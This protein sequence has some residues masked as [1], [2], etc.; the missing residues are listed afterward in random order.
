MIK[1]IYRRLTAVAT[2]KPERMLTDA[3]LKFTA[4]LN[5]KK[6]IIPMIIGAIPVIGVACSFLK[7]GQQEIS[8]FGKDGL[9]VPI[10]LSFL[11]LFF[12]YCCYKVFLDRKDKLVI[13]AGGIWLHKSGF[14][15]WH[16]I[17]YIYLRIIKGKQTVYTLF[18][19]LNADDKEIKFDIT[20]LDKTAP[21]ILDALQHYS[22]KNGILFLD[23]EVFA[24]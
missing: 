1:S 3:Q 14:I 18:I 11:L 21:E 15:E 12:F 20:D 5:R 2:K 4:K 17:W 22:Q 8:E 10:L 16:L 23:T 6:L 24:P 13:D 19:R 9:G 7:N